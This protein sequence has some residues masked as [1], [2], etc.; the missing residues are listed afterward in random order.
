MADGGV[1]RYADAMVFAVLPT[2]ELP[3]SIETVTAL[4]IMSKDVESSA[5]AV[6]AG[7]GPGV[8]GAGVVGQSPHALH[9]R[10][11]SHFRDHAIFWN[12]V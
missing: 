12:L 7:V 6:G 3:H 10:N 4:A 9:V 8:G 1:P 5:L 2:A 11:R